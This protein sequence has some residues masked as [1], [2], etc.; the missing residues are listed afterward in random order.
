MVVKKITNYDVGLGINKNNN[1]LP[2]GGYNHA[3]T[4]RL[5]T[6]L[7][8]LVS[9]VSLDENIPEHQYWTEYGPG[10]MLPVEPTLARDTNKASYLDEC[11]ATIRGNSM[12]WYLILVLFY[13][14]EIF[15][16]A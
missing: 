10:Y 9:G 15:D 11:I 8:A 14:K 2:T 16:L 6:S 7:T 12:K 4:A 5:W 13:F 1:F 3:N